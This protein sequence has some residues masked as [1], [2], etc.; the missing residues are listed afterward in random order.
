MF[1]VAL[2][3]IMF[4]LT[5]ALHSILPFMIAAAVSKWCVDQHHH[6]HLMSV[7]LLMPF[8]TRECMLV[9]ILYPSH[10]LVMTHIF[11]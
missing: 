9:C 4:E 8:I 3:V 11:T 7:G 1:I 10:T 2:V 5:G 6:I